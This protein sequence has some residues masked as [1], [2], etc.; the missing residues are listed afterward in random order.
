MWRE[1]QVCLHTLSKGNCVQQHPNSFWVVCS[2]RWLV[3]PL[4]VV[5]FVFH[6]LI[7]V[8]WIIS[9]SLF[10]NTS[11]GIENCCQCFPVFE[12]KP[13]QQPICLFKTGKR[14]DSRT[15]LEQYL[16]CV[17]ASGAMARSP[18]P[19]R[20]PLAHL[21]T[22]KP[23]LTRAH[24]THSE[25]RNSVLFRPVPEMEGWASDK[26]CI[27]QRGFHVGCWWVSS[28]SPPPARGLGGC[29]RAPRP[30][31][32]V[33]PTSKPPWENLKSG[34]D[35]AAGPATLEVKVR[36]NH[37]KFATHHHFLD[38]EINRGGLGG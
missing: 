3:F 36:G 37:V 21:F 11:K 16:H 30:T 12:K 7:S 6:S 15:S 28:P 25:E 31:R 9:G 20:A 32:P 22:F 34:P 13:K 33:S 4:E 38:R 19:R 1:G 35:V 5:T 24:C 10:L 17:K 26:V 29:T 2:F 14:I 18:F 8:T 23:R 27:F